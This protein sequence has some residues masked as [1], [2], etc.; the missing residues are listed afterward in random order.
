MKAN[1]ITVGIKYE[2]KKADG[3]LITAICTYKEE[4]D[5]YVTAD[6]GRFAYCSKLSYVLKYRVEV[7]AG[8][9]S[10]WKDIND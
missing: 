7:S 3:T 6:F 9:W 10:D 8:N 2:F 5:G 4:R 1:D